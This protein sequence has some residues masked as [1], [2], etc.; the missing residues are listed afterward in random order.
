MTLS[1]LFR[2]KPSG[3]T[4]I[5]LLMTITL[6]GILTFASIA[7]I[8][9]TISESKFEETVQRLGRF[10]LA[11]LGDSAL[12]E[13]GVRTNFGFVGDVGSLPTYSQGL[14][15]LVTR[16]TAAGDSI[17]V[18]TINSAA[19]FGA[20]W[21]GPYVGANVGSLD[22]ANDAWGNQIE[23]DPSTSPATIKSYGA[24]LV[25]GGSG[26]DQDIVIEIEDE[27]FKGTVHGFINDGGVPF[28]NDAEVVLYEAID[29]VVTAR[30]S[31]FLVA[32]NKGYFS[33]S[34]VPY[35]RR[36][37]VVYIPSQ[38][39]PAVQT[40]GPVLFTMEKPNQELHESW[41]DRNP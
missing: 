16:P 18:Y 15:S 39:D 23:Y 9:D 4:L 3:V 12:K 24:D 17:P 30:A 41:F 33:F 37:I 27:L 7:L 25:A 2:G 34:D 19:R 31:Q 13:N 35:G 29:G 21:N 1:S 10:K 11:I 14:A 20:G 6:M 8:T 28:E 36:S 22:T 26:Y 40:L 32:A 5:E 38:T